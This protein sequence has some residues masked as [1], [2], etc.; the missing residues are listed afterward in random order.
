M[1]K[2]VEAHNNNL[3]NDPSKA[4]QVKKDAAAKIRAGDITGGLSL[5]EG[6]LQSGARVNGATTDGHINVTELDEL[7]KRSGSAAGENTATPAAGGDAA[8]KRRDEII[9]YIPTKDIT[10]GKWPVT[11][12]NTTKEFMITQDSKDPKKKHIAKTDFDELAKHLGVADSEKEIL[13]EG[14]AG[15]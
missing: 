11:M 9:G 7:A 10:P 3:F 1:A 8:S 2:A 12:G 13:K 5:L 6:K 15:K 14:L 4:D